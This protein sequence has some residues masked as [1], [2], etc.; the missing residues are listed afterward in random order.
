[1]CFADS[2]VNIDLDPDQLT[3]VDYVCMECKNKFKGIGKKVSCPACRSTNV[4]KS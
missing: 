3:V 4:E 1:M 2:S